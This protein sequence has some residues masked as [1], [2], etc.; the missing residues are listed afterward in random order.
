MAARQH[1]DLQ[2]VAP[3]GR[4]RDAHADW[5]QGQ[6]CIHRRPSTDDARKLASIGRYRRREFDRPM[7]T[8]E[9]RP[10]IHRRPVLST[11][12]R[13]C[14]PRDYALITKVYMTT[15]TAARRCRGGAL[16]GLITRCLL[17]AT[18]NEHARVELRSQPLLSMQS[19]RSTRTPMLPKYTMSGVLYTESPTFTAQAKVSINITYKA[20]A[21][22]A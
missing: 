14:L 16:R 2:R 18:F 10:P 5:R 11:M 22:D 15:A 7:R 12:P 19:S 3:E 13:H 9:K 21:Q 4:I 6:P 1:S 20:D 8:G 17:R